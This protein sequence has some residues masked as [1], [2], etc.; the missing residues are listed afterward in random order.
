MDLNQDWIWITHH[1]WTI[2]SL[3][4]DI[5]LVEKVIKDAAAK[6]GYKEIVSVCDMIANVL[7]FIL[8]I[9]TGIFSALKNKNGGS[10]EKVDPGTPIVPAV[11][12]DPGKS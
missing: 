3:I 1:V 10:N 8:D 5:L 12:V 2:L 4:G 9:I 6:R 7:N 11:P